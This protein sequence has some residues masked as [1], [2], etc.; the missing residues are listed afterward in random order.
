[1]SQTIQGSVAFSRDIFHDN[2]K[3]RFI[4]ITLLLLFNEEK[5]TTPF[6]PFYLCVTR[7]VFNGQRREYC[8]VITLFTGLGLIFTVIVLWNPGMQ[9]NSPNSVTARLNSLVKRRT[10]KIDLSCIACVQHFP[11]IH[12]L[13]SGVVDTGAHCC[14]RV[15]WMLQGSIHL[16]CSLGLSIDS[17]YDVRHTVFNNASQPASQSARDGS[18]ELLSDSGE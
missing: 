1:M 5:N 6:S 17:S 14:R 18:E 11:L 4:P 9:T 3:Q 8:G 15:N 12:I 7:S 13:G 16:G 10:P 2:G